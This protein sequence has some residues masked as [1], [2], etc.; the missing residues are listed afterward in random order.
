MAPADPSGP[1]QHLPKD[2]ETIWTPPTDTVTLTPVGMPH[3]VQMCRHACAAVPSG[4]EIGIGMHTE[5]IPSG[6]SRQIL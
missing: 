1:A 3:V 2:F 5:P 4:T 6:R